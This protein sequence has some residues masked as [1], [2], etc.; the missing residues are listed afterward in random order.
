MPLAF[1]ALWLRAFGQTWILGDLLSE[2]RP[3]PGPPKTAIV[4]P[5]G[6]GW[7]QGGLQ[8]SR[9]KGQGHEGERA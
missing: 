8:V 7:S 4:V 5:S 9:A 3:R 2:K 1:N 6:Q